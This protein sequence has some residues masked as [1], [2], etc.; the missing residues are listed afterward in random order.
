METSRS[1]DK[2]SDTESQRVQLE[3]LERLE[4][5]YLRLTRTQNN[6]EVH[7]IMHFGT[8]SFCPKFYICV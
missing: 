5:E 2:Q 8:R 4:Q 7:T 3:K 6:A 1:A